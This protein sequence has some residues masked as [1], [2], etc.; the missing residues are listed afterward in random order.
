MTYKHIYIYNRSQLN[1]NYSDD[2][3]TIDRVHIVFP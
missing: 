2:S 3:P 1:Y